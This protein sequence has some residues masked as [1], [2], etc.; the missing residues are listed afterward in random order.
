MDPYGRSRKGNEHYGWSRASNKITL[1]RLVASISS[2]SFTYTYISWRDANCF[3]FEASWTSL[4]KQPCNFHKPKKVDNQKGFLA[5][6]AVKIVLNMHRPSDSLVLSGFS[7]S[8]TSIQSIGWKY[9]LDRV[10][11]KWSKKITDTGENFSWRKSLFHLP[12][13]PL[14]RCLFHLPISSRSFIWWIPPFFE[15]LQVER[16]QYALFT[17]WHLFICKPIPFS[18]TANT[19]IFI[20]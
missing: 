16:G 1:L 2:M 9:S 5:E 8:I 13:D 15:R 17:I 19:V 20:C 18:M 3:W 7:E 6:K 4:P 14:F 12:F 10:S 11:I